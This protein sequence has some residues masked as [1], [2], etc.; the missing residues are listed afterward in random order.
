MIRPDMFDVETSCLGTNMPFLFRY[1][2]ILLCLDL[3]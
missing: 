3:V 1:R 2:E